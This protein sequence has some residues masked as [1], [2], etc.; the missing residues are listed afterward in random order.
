MSGY[1]VARQHRDILYSELERLS[2]ALNQFPRMAN[3]LTPG[4]VKASPEYRAA[5][6]DYDATFQR[7]REFN[8]FFTRAYK[9]ELRQERRSRHHAAEAA[10]KEG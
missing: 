1:D 6:R 9:R 3:G 5:K 4:S 7:L 8:S 2:A 10:T